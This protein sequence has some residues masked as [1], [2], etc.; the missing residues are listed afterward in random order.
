MVEQEVGRKVEELLRELLL[1]V[2]RETEKINE[3][4]KSDNKNAEL[5]KLIEELGGNGFLDMMKRAREGDP[6]KQ[7][8][9]ADEDFKEFSTLLKQTKIKD[10]EAM[11]MVGD[12]AKIFC[13]SE[14]DT[15]EVQ[16]ALEALQAKRGLITEM[17]PEAFFLTT[18]NEDICALTNFDDVE[19]E[20]IRHNARKTPFPYAI[21]DVNGEPTLLL[22]TENLDGLNKALY[23]TSYALSGEQGALVRKQIEY[24]LKGRQEVNIAME[25]AEREFI[26]V[27]KNNPNNYIQATSE[28]FIYYK[29]NKELE[30]IPRS[31][32]GASEV[33]YQR[34]EGLTQPV[35]LTYDEFKLPVSERNK[36]LEEK[37]AIYP[38]GYSA[39]NDEI[40]SMN[41]LEHSAAAKEYNK[42]FN[43]DY[44]KNKD[45]SLDSIL[46]S[47]KENQDSRKPEFVNREQEYDR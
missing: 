46:A 40:E 47:I 12:N 17:D 44:I 31:E 27:D 41:N 39:V 3:L 43:K 33:A 9:V 14:S 23:N 26:I 35:L 13:F 10:F 15:Q 20:L 28:D 6:I 34:L 11:D 25:D 8:Y 19:L 36:L 30:R 42:K 32:Q 18:E 4:I 5:R 16:K 21:A 22:K 29:N 38:T 2:V 45:N 24:R 37:T 1:T 7:I